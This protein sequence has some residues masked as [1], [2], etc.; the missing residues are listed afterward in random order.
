[1]STIYN[2]KILLS[3]PKR[4]LRSAEAK[5]EPA[6][7]RSP[8]D[9][10]DQPKMRVRRGRLLILGA[11]FL[12]SL[13]IFVVTT[14]WLREALANGSNASA[15]WSLLPWQSVGSGT[16]GTVIETSYEPIS[17]SKPMVLIGL[18]TIGFFL[19]TLR[20]IEI[21]RASPVATE[22]SLADW[23]TA[24]QKKINQE[25]TDVLAMFRSHVEKVDNHS[26]SLA[27]GQTGLEQAKTREQIRAIVRHLL[28][29]NEK[30][31]QANG[32]YEQKL[33]ESRSQIESLRAA[34]KQSQEITARDPLTNTFSRGY[35]E[36]SFA[37][38]V[39]EAKQNL[40]DLSLVMI[41]LDNF[42]NI[43]DTFGHPVGD[44]VIKKFADLMIEA[45]KDQG[46]V[47]RYGGE[48]FAIVLP[49]TS[50]AQAAGVAERIRKMLETQ[51]WG[52][53]GGPKL[54]K[55]TASFG[56]SQL[57]ADEGPEI[58][59]EKADAK[60][61]ESKAAGRNRVSA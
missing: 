52:V 16:G 45:T 46:Y 25:L 47:A 11:E 49:A 14:E 36:T 27:N 51:R 21:F 39:A 19:G 40:A 3:L 13:A 60:L 20:L 61:Y 29:E 17:I 9:K 24:A 38:Q 44:E 30:M 1:M 2:S 53:R 26:A 7:F 18:A 10:T 6:I 59:I 5:A 37:K 35:F 23:V 56:V 4:Q 48:E 31:R 28:A 55:V 43:N 34:L 57:N 22:Q 58:L 54:G 33:R 15:L 41:D 42:K 12:A 8:I 32:S 50:G